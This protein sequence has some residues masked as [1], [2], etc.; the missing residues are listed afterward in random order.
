[1]QLMTQ[2]SLF[3][4]VRQFDLSTNVSDHIIDDVYNALINILRQASDE[5][6]PRSRKNFLDIGGIAG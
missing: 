5:A 1:M 4:E 6:V 2:T 3:E